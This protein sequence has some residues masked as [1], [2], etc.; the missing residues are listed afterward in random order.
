M[1]NKTASKDAD[2]KNGPQNNEASTGFF[3]GLSIGSDPQVETTVARPEHD[4]TMVLDSTENENDSVSLTTPGIHSDDLPP[5]KPANAASSSAKTLK[6][7]LHGESHGE[8]NIP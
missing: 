1:G 4:A 3:I 8:K 6:D 5:T 7:K 2:W